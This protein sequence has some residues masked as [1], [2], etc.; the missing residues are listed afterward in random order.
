M[1]AALIVY[2]LA[3]GVIVAVSACSTSNPS[4]QPGVSDGISDED[5]PALQFPSTGLVVRVLDSV[6]IEVE[7]E[8]ATFDVRYMGV[9]VPEGMDRE[10]ALQFNRFLVEG[11][12]VRMFSD[13]IDADTDGVPLRYV[14][15]DGEMVNLKLLASGWARLAEF[16]PSFDL[17]DEF[18]QA[19]N[20]ARTDGRGLWKAAEPP[21][22]GGHETTAPTAPTAP[23]AP[24]PAFTG[25]TLPMPP[26]FSSSG[27]CDYSGTSDPIIKGNIDQR[28]AEHEYH[29]PGGLFYSTT[30]IEPSDGE[31]W[32]CTE[33][34]AV[35]RGWK[36]SKY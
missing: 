27:Q 23:E 8:G 32:F 2:G 29:V 1:A 34:E 16:P 26:G 13:A 4:E 12:S 35:S 31:L 24:V 6:T 7:S 11:K 18:S 22:P 17:L 28:N 3:F 19:E 21:D 36:R 25:G 15:S 30:V 10:G 14:Y 9:A 5:R 33:A 20:G